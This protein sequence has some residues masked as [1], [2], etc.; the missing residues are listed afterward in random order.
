MNVPARYSRNAVRKLFLRV[1]DDRTLPGHGFAERSAGDEEETDGR[2]N[3]DHLDPAAVAEED[4]RVVAQKGLPLEFEIAGR[5][6][7]V[8]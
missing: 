2:V 3:R 4:D 1:H 8:R 6:D 7:V 5:L